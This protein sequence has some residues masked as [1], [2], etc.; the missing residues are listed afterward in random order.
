MAGPSDEADLM[1]MLRRMHK[2]RLMSEDIVRA[3]VQRAI[4]PNRNAPDAGQAICAIIGEPGRIEA[5]IGLAM[6]SPWYSSAQ[7]IGPRWFHV[8]PEYRRQDHA[9]ALILFAKYAADALHMT[10]HIRNDILAS[11]E[12]AAED[13]LWKRHLGAEWCGSSYLYQPIAEGV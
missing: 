13:R 1:D 11:Q 12:A 10:L 2:G 6:A 4:T 8:V 5:S 9:R 3:E 7:F